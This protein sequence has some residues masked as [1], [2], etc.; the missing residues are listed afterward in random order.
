[1]SC[2]NWEILFPLGVRFFFWCGPSSK[3]CSTYKPGAAFRKS[4]EIQD[5]CEA[6]PVS[7]WSPLKQTCSQMYLFR[8]EETTKEKTTQAAG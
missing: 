7:N 5:A 6:F 3:H 4:L 1:M 2:V 8:G